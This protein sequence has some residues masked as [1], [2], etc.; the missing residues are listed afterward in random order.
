METL[1]VRDFDLG[2]TVKAGMLFAYDEPAPREFVICD[3]ER[4]FYVRQEGSMLSYDGIT[5]Y[6]LKRFFDLEKDIRA[7][8]AR[9]KT[10]KAL[11]PVLPKYKGLRLVR[12]DPRQAILTF[13]M[14]SNNNQTRIKRMMDA[15]RERHG[16]RIVVGGHAT[17][18]LPSRG[19]VTTLDHLDGLKYG[20]RAEYLVEAERRL[21]KGFLNKL[22]RADY[23]GARELLLTLPGVG[24]KV[25]DCILAYSELAKGESFP[26]DVWV[27]RALKRWY[28]PSFKKRPLTDKHVRAFARRR[29]GEDAAYG[30]HYLFLAAQELLS[31]TSKSTHTR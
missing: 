16:E 11:A 28:A 25:A 14:S 17:S 21:S 6:G 18:A 9:L 8:H 7:L 5:E 20:Y 4:T 29:F 10:E 1:S 2:L 22:E 23:D 31:R 27:K 3:G 15:F 24:P 19:A 26:A 13:I 12:Q 30:Q